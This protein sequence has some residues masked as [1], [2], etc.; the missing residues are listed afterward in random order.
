[1]THLSKE[2]TSG[3]PGN[4]LVTIVFD[5]TGD[6]MLIVDIFARTNKPTPVNITDRQFI[7]LAGHVSIT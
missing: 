6:N 3:Y 1:M 7:N 4:L 2:G 5:V